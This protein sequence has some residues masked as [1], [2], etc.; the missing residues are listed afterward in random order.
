MW[1]TLTENS[2]YT[3]SSRGE[4]WGELR[5]QVTSVCGSSAVAHSDARVERGD[6]ALCT[7]KHRVNGKSLYVLGTQIYCECYTALKPESNFLNTPKYSPPG[8]R[9]SRPLDWGRKKLLLTHKCPYPR[10]GCFPF[11]PRNH[12]N[13]TEQDL[14]STKAPTQPGLQHT[15]N[16]GPKVLPP[17]PHTP[18][19]QVSWHSTYPSR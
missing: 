11:H 7:C 18:G 1:Y 4:A 12:T 9:Y 5:L 15:T 2:H 10:E 6:R 14:C 13:A 19:A 16:R 3:Y 17:C 8:G